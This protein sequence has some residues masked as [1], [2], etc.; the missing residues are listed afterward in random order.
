MLILLPP[1]EGKSPPDSGAPVDL[2]ALSFPELTATRVDVMAALVRLCEM[3]PDQAVTT[4]GLGPRQADD[5]ARNA[6]LARSP[7]A[8]ARDVY[9][10]V[11]FDALGLAAPQ[12]GLDTG[13]DT[14]LD[15]E[16]ARRAD[17][18][19]GIVS[20][21]WG[22]LRPTDRIPAYRLGGGVSLPGIGG[23]AACWRPAL[24]EVLPSAA[25]GGVVVDLRSSTY[26]S[27]WRPSPDVAENV[28]KVRVLH[29]RGDGKRVVVSHHN[30]ATKGRLVRAILE[31]DDD[32][33]TAADLAAMIVGLG[34]KA[35][36]V[37]PQSTGH[38]WTLDVV[39][40]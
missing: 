25:A 38:S 31:H 9:T 33:E 28:V 26:A 16:A 13:L 36:L 6:E 29:E 37:E 35:E 32:P 12:A 20:G 39:T 14:G 7:A 34:W 27:F 15:A 3:D 17:E 30:K 2:D 5:V 22:L 1:S 4:L 10:G 21:L 23:L 18:R 19:I 24:R 8:P 11:L 40:T